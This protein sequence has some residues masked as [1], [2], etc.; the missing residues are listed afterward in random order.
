ML[1]GSEP[2]DA[3][4]PHERHGRGGDGQQDDEQEGM[5]EGRGWKTPS[6]QF[7]K[8]ILEELTILLGDR[9]KAFG[10]STQAFCLLRTSN[11]HER[12]KHCGRVARALWMG[13]AGTLSTSNT[14]KGAFRPLFHA[15]CRK[16]VLAKSSLYRLS[17]IVLRLI[18]TWFW[19]VS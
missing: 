5:G 17:G 8:A 4:E 13:E 7:P 6:L 3:P 15:F 19:S 10:Y 16:L 2:P 18:R 11:L 12:N 1:F 14:P 9:N